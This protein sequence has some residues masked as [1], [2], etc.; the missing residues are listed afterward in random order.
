MEA[1]D[2]TWY[3]ISTGTTKFELDDIVTVA[4]SLTATD[5]KIQKWLWRVYARYLPHF[6][7]ATQVVAAGGRTLTF[8]DANPDTVTASSGSFITDGYVVGQQ[9]TVAGTSSNNGTYTLAT[10]AATVL[11]VLS[12]DTFAAEGPLSGGETLDA[13]PTLTDPS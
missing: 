2:G 4:D 9:L 10:V 5:S 12:T 7:N 8:A 11:T 1:F 6:A 13:G 3:H